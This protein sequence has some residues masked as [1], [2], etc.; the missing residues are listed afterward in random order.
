MARLHKLPFDTVKL[1]RSFVQ[2]LGEGEPALAQSVYDMAGNMGLELIAEGVETV[3]ECSALVAMGYHQFQGYLF[4]K[5]MPL[6]DLAPWLV[7]AS[8]SNLTNFIT[9]EQ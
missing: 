4:A 2:A 9:R 3:R 7:Q 5:P 6:V 1:D 8:S